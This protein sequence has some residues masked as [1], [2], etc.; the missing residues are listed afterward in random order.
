M[1]Y[2]K[3]PPEIKL[4]IWKL[5]LPKERTMHHFR[6]AMPSLGGEEPIMTMYP[7]HATKQNYP[8]WRDFWK[9]RY[10]DSAACY[11][12][13]LEKRLIIWPVPSS[14]DEEKIDEEKNGEEKN[15]E[16]KKEEVKK[17]EDEEKMDEVKKEDDEEKND[18]DEKMDE[19]K[20]EDN[21]EKMDEEKND[22]KKVEVKDED[23]V[24]VEEKKV[25]KKKVDKKEKEKKKP[26]GLKASIDADL[27]VVHFRFS[28]TAFNPYLLALEKNRKV[29]A[30][31]KSVAV[32]WKI[33]GVN[34]DIPP[35]T[36]LCRQ[37]QHLPFVCPFT[38][39]KWLSYFEDVEVFYVILKITRKD[40]DEGGMY[41]EAKQRFRQGLRER[42]EN[43]ILR[44]TV[45]DWAKDEA[46][47]LH[48]MFQ[49]IVGP[50]P[51]AIREWT[52][53]FRR[54]CSFFPSPTLRHSY[55]FPIQTLT[56]FLS[57]LA[58]IAERNGLDIIHDRGTSY[59]EVDEKNSKPLHKKSLIW[60]ALQDVRTVWRS[61]QVFGGSQKLQ[62]NAANTK[63]KLL[64]YSLPQD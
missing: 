39:A 4:E 52:S 33:N 56:Y 2:D 47:L 30:G 43:P 6:I 28:G 46:T 7:G 17:E 22:E 53:Y 41:H 32:D 34:W 5:V 24:K 40:I 44:E 16:V 59:Y 38:T 23:E 15:D 20:K 27:D 19:V 26:V 14:K 45:R 62:Q 48:K 42:R 61:G 12:V 35:F 9:F 64:V 37:Q 51:I 60:K 54:R 25:D 58:G 10:V 49:V 8:A 50:A 11:V 1:S 36:C 63:F 3:L 31:I 57:I 18:E 21:E 55:T 13:R 29:F